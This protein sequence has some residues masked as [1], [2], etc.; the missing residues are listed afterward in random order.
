[1]LVLVLVLGLGL[2]LG[3]VLVLGLVPDRSRKP[4]S[5]RRSGHQKLRSYTRCFQTVS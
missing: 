5:C 3:L 4:S 2:G 1:V